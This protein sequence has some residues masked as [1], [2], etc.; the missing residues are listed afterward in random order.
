MK[1][2]TWL[3]PSAP[4][5]LVLVSQRSALERLGE[6]HLLRE[7]QIRAVVVGELVVVA[8]GDRVEWAG[9]LAVAAEDA[10]RQVDLVHLRVALSRR[11]AVLGGVLRSHHADAVGRAGGRAQ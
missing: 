2:R 8:H 5:S 11:D 3:T 4:R 6:Q 10:T 9:E 1:N 7:D